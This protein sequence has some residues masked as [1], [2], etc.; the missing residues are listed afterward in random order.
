MLSVLP[1]GKLHPCVVLPTRRA[2]NEVLWIQE[3]PGPSVAKKL[4][5]SAPAA[6]R[7]LVKTDK[8]DAAILRLL[9]GSYFEVL[10]INYWYIQT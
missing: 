9:D 3:T 5:T 1:E 8:P 2:Y 10:F 4:P 6:V 7:P